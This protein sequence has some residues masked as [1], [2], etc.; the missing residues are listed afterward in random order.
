MKKTDEIA[1]PNSCLG[2]DSDAAATIR[3]WAGRR[4]L[5]GK[6]ERGDPQILKALALAEALDITHRKITQSA[7]G[8]R[9]DT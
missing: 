5:R 8:P 3:F 7:P 4:V 6:N 2:R 9:R 1:D